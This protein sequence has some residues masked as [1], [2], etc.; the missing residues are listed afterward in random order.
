MNSNCKCCKA[1]ITVFTDSPAPVECEA[2]ET[3][4]CKC[5]LLPKHFINQRGLNTSKLVC[6]HC[7]NLIEVN[8]ENSDM[9]ISF[10]ARVALGLK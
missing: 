10:E 6:W 5:G 9:G 2:C 1:P 7:N 4:A 8:F 3:I